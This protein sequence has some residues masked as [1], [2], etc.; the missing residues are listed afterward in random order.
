M[1]NRTWTR[2]NADQFTYATGAY[3]IVADLQHPK[4]GLA[5]LREDES[6]RS[7]P[8]LFVH[9]LCP[10]AEL[11][12]DDAYV[13]GTCLV[14]SFV[15]NSPDWPGRLEYACRI[16][17]PEGWNLP[18]EGFLCLTMLSYTTDASSCSGRIDLCSTAC[19]SASFHQPTGTEEAVLAVCRLPQPRED[20]ALPKIVL[21]PPHF[22]LFDL[23]DSSDA[24]LFGHVGTQEF[25]TELAGGP[26][27]EETPETWR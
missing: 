6:A 3:R 26:L 27:S 12:L 2:N 20:G 23:A 14:A 21:P 19:A 11:S 13:R 25:P 17:R 4:R 24:V 7:D 1:G 8:G 16:A 18:D 5:V 15:S 9:A 22:L 10:P